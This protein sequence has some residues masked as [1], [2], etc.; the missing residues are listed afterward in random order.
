MA[1][2]VTAKDGNS[3][4]IVKNA[5]VKDLIGSHDGTASITGG[6]VTG[7]V[8]A[9]DGTVKAENTKVNESVNAKNGGTV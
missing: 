7:T 3:Q 9:D 5:T 8:S 1:G 2:Q 6:I 4:A